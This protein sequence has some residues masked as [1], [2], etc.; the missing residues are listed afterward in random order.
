MYIF[1]LHLTSALDLLC[2]WYAEGSSNVVILGEQLLQLCKGRLQAQV[3]LVLLE[4]I[5]KKVRARS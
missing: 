3:I 5:G 1:P 2:P 4:W